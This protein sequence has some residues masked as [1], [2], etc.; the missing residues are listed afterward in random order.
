LEARTALAGA[1]EPTVH[2]KTPESIE[3][4]KNAGKA[5]PF[6]SDSPANPGE[7]FVFEREVSLVDKPWDPSAN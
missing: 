1:A 3:F 7:V 6:T 2:V 4:Y 5:D